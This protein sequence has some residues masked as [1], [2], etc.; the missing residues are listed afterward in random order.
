MDYFAIF[1]QSNQQTYVGDN[2]ETVDVLEHEQGYVVEVFES[3]QQQKRFYNLRWDANKQDFY[4]PLT[5]AFLRDQI[6][7]THTVTFIA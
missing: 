6:G 2:G 4:F 5:G 7:A 3:Q 1:S